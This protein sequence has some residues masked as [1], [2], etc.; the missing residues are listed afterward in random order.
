MV[1]QKQGNC[2]KLRHSPPT[3]YSGQRKGGFPQERGPRRFDP[4]PSW[5]DRFWALVGS[6]FLGGVRDLGEDRSEQ[7]SGK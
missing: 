4:H 3:L 6:T 1:P 2:S 5:A 7:P